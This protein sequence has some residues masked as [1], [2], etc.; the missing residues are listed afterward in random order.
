MDY[1]NKQRA[2]VL[3]DGEGNYLADWRHLDVESVRKVSLLIS[4]TLRWFVSHFQRC[5]TVLLSKETLTKKAIISWEREMFSLVWE[6]AEPNRGFT[7]KQKRHV[8]AYLIKVLGVKEGG[9][10]TFGAFWEAMTK[11]PLPAFST[12]RSILLS[13]PS[14]L[15]NAQDELVESRPALFTYLEKLTSTLEE[16]LQ[17]LRAYVDHL[18]VSLEIK[19]EVFGYPSQVV[20]SRAEVEEIRTK[21]GSFSHVTVITSDAEGAMFALGIIPSTEIFKPIL[22]TVSLRDF[23]N[24]EETKVPSYF[25]VI[26]V[27]D[28]HKSSLTTLSA[29]TVNVADAQSAN[30]LVAELAFEIN[31]TYGTSGCDENGVYSQIQELQGSLKSSDSC[32]LLKRLLQKHLIQAKKLPY[33]I[34]PRR[35]YLEYLQCLYAILDDTDLL[36]KVSYRDVVCVT[37]LLNRMKTIQLQKEV[38]VLSLEDLPRDEKFA[39]RAA[40]RILQN[41]EMYSL[42]KKIYDAKEQSTEHNIRLCAQKMPSNVF[43]DTKVQNGCCRVGQTKIFAKNFP[44][45]SNHAQEMRSFWCEDAML[46]TRERPDCDLHM[47]M[48]S[49]IPGAEEVYKGN[50]EEFKHKDELWFWIPMEEQAIEHLKTFLNAFRASPQV[51][52]HPMEVEFFGKD[53]KELEKIFKESFSSI[54]KTAT[55]REDN[56]LTSVAVLRYKAGLLNSRKAMISPYLPKL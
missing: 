46:F 11:I 52:K 48:I 54:A 29:T 2:V 43:A 3:V 22:G 24:R 10:A 34:D 30:A 56:S 18:G 1:E 5:L 20:S 4:S 38:E 39:S 44:F 15:F 25:E 55:V 19:K 45:Y 27:V 49:T 35:E 40:E 13:Y 31:D 42:Y 37:S 47:H 41:D 8:E 28:H 12:F 21:M 32:R 50:V 33:F 7:E 6:E 23:C 17:S 16:A 26:S 9:K 14:S 36:S 53:K 51:A